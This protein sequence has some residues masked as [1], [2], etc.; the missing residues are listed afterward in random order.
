MAKKKNL[1]EITEVAES[2]N[3]GANNE[4]PETEQHLYHLTKK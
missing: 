4:N 3:V 1:D 2:T